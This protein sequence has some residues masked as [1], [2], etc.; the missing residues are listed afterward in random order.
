MEN[1]IPANAGGD[2]VLL[3]RFLREQVTGMQSRNLGD[4]KNRLNSIGWFVPPF[5]SSGLLDT[6]ALTIARQNGAF[7]QADLE[8]VLARVYDAERLASM[9]LNRYPET[10]VIMLF[11]QTISEAVMAHFL[12]LNHVAVGGLIPVVEGAGRRLATERGLIGQ[13]QIKKVFKSLTGY[14]KQEVIARQIGATDEIVNMLDSFL[15]FIEHY[16]FTR[17]AD[18]PLMDRTNRN[19]I[20]HGA[21]PDAEYGRP[22]SFYKTIAAVDFLTFVSSLSTSKMSGFVPAHTPQSTALAERYV[23][24]ASQSLPVALVT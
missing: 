11:A 6:V 1:V 23:A 2:A 3:H 10:P 16:F 17:S 18:Y 22:I 5:F 20:A 15:G 9:V 13:E 14:S 8:G 12:R 24:A 7:T 19:G 4:L 21:Y